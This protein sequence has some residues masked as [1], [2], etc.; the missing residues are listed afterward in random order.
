MLRPSCP[1][2][3]RATHRALLIISVACMSLAAAP[4]PSRADD[5]ASEF[6]A[7]ANAASQRW[8]YG[9]TPIRGG[10]FTLF[11][12]SGTDAFGLNFWNHAATQTLVSHNS[13]GL[14][15]NIGSNTTIPDGGLTL[16]PGSSVEYAVVRWTAPASG[17]VS[18]RAR[19]TRRST[20]GFVAADVAVL[21]GAAVLFSQW[22]T[23][24]VAN[25]VSMSASVLVSPGET[26]D[27]A[28]GP[29]DGANN[30]DMIGL[31]A[32]VW[33]EPIYTSA[34]PVILFGGERF[35]ACRGD[36]AFESIAYDPLNQRIASRD[37]IRTRCGAPVF[38]GTEEHPGLTW[39]SATASFWQVT[40][41]RVVRRWS[42]SGAFL[43]N[44]FTVPPT[45]NV[46]G[47]GLDTLDAVKGIA[48]DSSHVYLVDAGPAGEQGEIY[49]NEWFKF[50]RAGVPVKSSK[51]TDF[52]ANLDLSP[53]AIVDDIVYSPFSS[54]IFPG[55]FLIALEHSGIQ[56][57]DAEG[58]FVDKF[59]WTDPGV[60]AGA[61]LNAF[62][63]LGLDPVDGNLYLVDNDGSAS[64]IWTR[65]PEDGPT[66]YAIGTG[67]SQPYLQYPNPGCN[68][69]LWKSLPSSAG[70]GF[71]CAYRTA[72][73]TAY[74][75]DFGSGDISRFVP[76]TGFGGRVALTGAYSIWGVAYDPLRDVLYGGVEYGGPGNISI[77]VINPLTGAASPLPSP[78][79]YSTRDLAF[80]PGDQKLYG[81]ASVGGG[82]KLIRIE[83]DTGAGTVVGPTVDVVGIDYDAASNRLIGILNPG[84]PTNA[85]LWSINPATGASTLIT[86]LPRNV[87]WEGIAVVP[88]GAA[89]TVSVE[90]GQANA[91]R[92]S[93]RVM[94]NPSRGPAALHF[95]LPA[96]AQV[97]AAVY[98]VGGRKVCTIG[99]GRYAAGAHTMQWD[100][101]DSAG[102]MVPS[103]VYFARLDRGGESQVARMVRL[104]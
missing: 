90:I 60:P 30:S 84:G 80:Y 33:L 11:A 32:T 55:K 76:T 94:P 14:A 70:L 27:F 6:S 38:Q 78:V 101:R 48:V 34:G 77:V 74:T 56:V 36:S 15:K 83:R 40:N 21:H 92:S 88:V 5:A 26:I 66:Y 44:V 51:L 68:Q 91:E 54:P 102:N 87:A 98:D 41:A 25:T 58:N 81:V 49:S 3:S 37:I 73:R 57:V 16:F 61:R 22:L 96:A 42:A 72:N 46:P 8:T 97:E 43:G 18:I 45:F 12:T 99:R 67:G 62:A 52:H 7:N 75:V 31:D 17:T 100:G 29:A 4:A 82:P 85:T 24:D 13:T 65:L 95:S 89:P 64:Q 28:V 103:G 10:A 86:T 39:D 93:L 69:P 23:N 59:R 79:G 35:V 104:E 20:N 19:F 2:L 47:W 63:G 50:T 1:A 9:R 71:G 53:D